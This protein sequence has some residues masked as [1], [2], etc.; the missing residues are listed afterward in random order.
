MTLMYS[1]FVSPSHES[2]L[3]C[4]FFHFNGGLSP[5][6]HL[7]YTYFVLVWIWELVFRH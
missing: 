6:T 4:Q 5:D 3:P 1:F 7:M 2:S